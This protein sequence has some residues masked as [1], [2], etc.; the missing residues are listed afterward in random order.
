MLHLSHSA[1]TFM[2]RMAARNGETL[3]P[4]HH[5]CNMPG[6]TCFNEFKPI[7]C[8]ERFNL[9]AQ[10]DSTFVAVERGL[11][12]FEMC[13]DS[14]DYATLVRNPLSRMDSLASKYSSYLPI[15][16]LMKALANQTMSVS[17]YSLFLQPPLNNDTAYNS[18]G[19]DD[20]LRP[21]RLDG[22]GMLWFDNALVRFLSANS[23]LPWTAALGR[24]G[25]AA[26]DAAKLTLSRFK[27][28]MTAETLSKDQATARRAFGSS[29]LNWTAMEF[30]PINDHG[31]HHMTQRQKKFF[32]ERNRWDICLYKHVRR[33]WDLRWM[34]PGPA[35]GAAPAPAAS[36]GGGGEEEAF[37]DVACPED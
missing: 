20:M 8:I 21:R 27:F 37:E 15:D 18:L 25:A 9:M 12:E 34:R 28:V 33:S 7:S 32:R 30:S 2:C 19:P 31:P 35:Q 11:Y 14:F 22:L 13:S 36:W 17:P 10:A 3:L 4:L 5:N 26:Y 1:G 16:E 29:V 23:T 24:I 6:D